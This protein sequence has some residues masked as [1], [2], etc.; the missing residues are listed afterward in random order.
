MIDNYKTINSDLVQIGDLLVIR[1]NQE[2][3]CDG[4]IV[5]GESLIDESM[6]T[7]ESVLIKKHKG[8]SVFGGTV[9][10][11]SLIYVKALKVGSDS[12]IEK[13]LKLVEEAQ[14]NKASIQLVADVISRYFVWAILALSILVFLVWALLYVTNNFPQNIL[15]PGFT[16]LML[17]AYFAID[18]LVISCPCALGLA[19]PTAVMVGTGVAAKDGILVRNGGQTLEQVSQ[20]NCVVFDKTGTLTIGKPIVRNFNFF[21]NI[22]NNHELT[23]SCILTLSKYSEHPLSKCINSFLKSEN[24]ELNYLQASNV[25]EIAGKGISGK[26]LDY[27]F[28]IGSEDYICNDVKCSLMEFIKE[29]LNESWRKN[30]LSVV[31]V[32]FKNGQIITPCAVF[33]ISDA[34]RSE[35]KHVITQL[36]NIGISTWLL[37]GDSF[38]TSC[39]IAKELGIP[40]HNVCAEVLPNEKAN[41]VREIRETMQWVESRSYIYRK[42]IQF[43]LKMR[44][45]TCESIHHGTKYIQDSAVVAMVGDGANDAIALAAADVGVSLGCGTDLAIS[46]AT[47][48]LMKSNL[49]DMLRLLQIGKSTINQIYANFFWAGI[50]NLLGITIAAGAFS[51]FG[52]RLQP[53]FAGFAMAMSSICVVLGSLSLKWRLKKDFD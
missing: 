50:Y 44:K 20:I 5:N 42:L 8:D 32:V 6:L 4:I 30:G 49:T 25:F 22:K 45:R 19:T 38:S 13:I 48:V 17:A 9:N 43:L 14:S 2:I 24:P 27:E 12:T 37:S 26:I 15:P 16:P 41:K 36:N 34:P 46:S 3:V 47:V 10:A 40:H 23:L 29:D 1:P 53:S 18:V 7:G 52:I 31:I 33:G 51:Q 11:T 28:Y 39:A 21:S 35:A